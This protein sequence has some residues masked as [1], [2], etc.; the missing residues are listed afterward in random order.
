MSEVSA[1]SSSVVKGWVAVLQLSSI[2]LRSS[3]AMC[4]KWSLEPARAS[5]QQMAKQKIWQDGSSPASHVSFHFLVTSITRWCLCLSVPYIAFYLLHHWVDSLSGN[6]PASLETVSDISKPQR[7]SINSSCLI[8]FSQ[9]NSSLNNFHC[10][11]LC[12]YL[13]F[14]TWFPFWE[15]SGDGLP[16]LHLLRSP[17]FSAFYFTALNM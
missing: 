16:Y 6:S 13:L 4:P 15:A 17:L 8:W 7:W 10:C 11:F 1:S 5:P 2:P 3:S 12:L 9:G 14:A